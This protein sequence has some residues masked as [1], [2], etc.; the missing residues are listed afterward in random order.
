MRFA[1]AVKQGT[2]REGTYQSL[3]T[4]THGILSFSSIVR[5]QI[6][7]DCF[8]DSVRLLLP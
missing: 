1:A 5:Q 2:S 8:T 7:I 3:D 6:A 4:L